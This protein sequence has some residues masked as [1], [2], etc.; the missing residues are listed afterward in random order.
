MYKGPCIIPN[1]GQINKIE[2][3]K[4]NK[5]TDTENIEQST[6]STFDMTQCPEGRQ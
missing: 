2:M 4:E 6:A 1:V 3:L 5:C